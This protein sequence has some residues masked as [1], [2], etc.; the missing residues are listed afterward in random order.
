M[1]LPLSWAVRTRGWY[2]SHFIHSVCPVCLE[3]CNFQ[4][5]MFGVVPSYAGVSAALVESGLPE[6]LLVH[7]VIFSC[8]LSPGTL[9]AVF[10]PTLCG[11]GVSCDLP[12]WVLASSCLFVFL[13]HHP[14]LESQAPTVAW[15]PD[16]DDSLPTCSSGPHQTHCPDTPHRRTWKGEWI[17]H[18]LMTKLAFFYIP[19]TRGRCILTQLPSRAP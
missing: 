11:F 15:P 2:W 19:A 1:E 13:A 10:W 18:H 16:S 6:D 14:R 5:A 17:F 4:N 8:A 12:V 7:I 3:Q 9:A